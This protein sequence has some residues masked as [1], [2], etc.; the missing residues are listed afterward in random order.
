M[1]NDN[2]KLIFIG[3]DGGT[4]DV[5]ERFIKN[6]KLKT[7]E[8]ILREGARG[9][10]SST[11]PPIS[12][13][14]WTSIF[15]GVNPGKHGVYGFVKE[16]ENTHFL[17]PITSKDRRCDSI[18]DITSKYGKRIIAMNI[19][20]SYP[21]DEVEGV[22]SSGL[23]TPSI[24]SKFVFPESFREFIIKKFPDFDVDF[25]EDEL[26]DN[27]KKLL[28]KIRKVTSAEIDLCKY[29]LENEEWDLFIFVFRAL[30][31][32]QHF[33]WNKTEIL[34]EFYEI[35]DKLLDYIIYNIINDGNDNI[36]LL[37]S[38]DHGFNDLSTI[39]YLNNWLESFDLLR[40]KKIRKRGRLVNAEKI[41]K[42]MLKF[43]LKK[44]TRRLKGKKFLKFLL[45]I[46]PSESIGYI[47][48]IDWAQTKAYFSEATYGIHIINVK[49]RKEYESIRE[50]I[51]RESNQL[52]DPVNGENI[53][54]KI[55][56][57]EELYNG[58]YADAGADIVF[59]KK[60]NYRFVGGYNT[61]GEILVKT[62][63]EIGD[64]NEEN[65]I[66]FVYGNDIKEEYTIKEVNVYDILPT[67]L[68]VLQI[69]IPPYID[70]QVLRNIFKEKSNLARRSIYYTTNNSEEERI[71]RKIKILK[72]S[73]KL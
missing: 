40:Y 34:V 66:L 55:Y 13:S 44:L 2:Y 19:P 18:W 59:L 24:R 1:S 38:S 6:N 67:I 15:T 41:Q 43:H 23:G 14:A 39:V 8:A 33:F 30:D 70:G 52:I 26:I 37:I 47:Y 22:M 35:F 31:V 58:E 36:I 49:N 27:P 54:K 45:N 60:E 12:P 63:K 68:H 17:I 16:D 21:P 28:N 9:R 57:R 42:V 20:L 25:D 71:R 62:R 64:H 48:N 29:L 72:T 32:I 4:Y 51:I 50:R 65:G 56:L 7:F 10:L 11:I 5:I 3:L 53:V 61:Q 46:I 73:H 69:P